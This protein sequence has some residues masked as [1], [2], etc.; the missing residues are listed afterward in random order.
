MATG[1]SSPLNF[2]WNT[3]NASNGTHTLFSRASDEAGKVYINLMTTNQVAVVDLRARKVLANW[4][5]APGGL[6]VGMTI[7]RDNGRLFIGCRGPQKLIVMS[8][9][10]G[11][12][13]SDMP[14][15]PSVYAV[16]LDGRQAFAS[17]AGSELFVAE[18][19]TPGKFEIVETVK[20][21]DGPQRVYH[22]L[23]NPGSARQH[24]EVNKGEGD[25][26]GNKR[27]VV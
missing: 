19:R 6:P 16:K 27:D 15:G 10:D 8:T 3:A 1:T 20:T 25:I 11:H 14:I 23:H 7:D 12:V 26:S 5:V 21:G 17:T 22:N 9:K 13:L 2:S 24:G 18:Q 4:P